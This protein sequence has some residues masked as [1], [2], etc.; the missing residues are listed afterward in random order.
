[1]A[2]RADGVQEKRVPHHD[3][4]KVQALV[5]Q[6]GPAAFTMTAIDGGRAMGLSTAAMVWVVANI[7]EGC[8]YKSMTSYGDPGEW[9]DVYHVQVPNNRVAYIKLVSRPVKPVLQFKER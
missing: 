2:I 3:L 1:V 5:L 4:A 6:L 8:F 9:Q 7:V